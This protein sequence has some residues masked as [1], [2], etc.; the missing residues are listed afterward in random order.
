M[1]RKFSQEDFINKAKIIHNNKYDYSK[2][3]YKNKKNKCNNYMS[4][5]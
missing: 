5:T 3:I 4:R 2:T 1:G